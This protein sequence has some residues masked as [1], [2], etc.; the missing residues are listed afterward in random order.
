MCGRYNLITDAQALVDFFELRNSLLI[1]PRY[2]IAPSQSIP[3]VRADGQGRELVFQR[4]GLVPHWAKES[5]IGYSMINARAETVAE[6]PSFRDA[7]RYRRCL[8]PA[9]GF[10]EWKP[11]NAGKQPYNIRIG[12]GLLFAFAGLWESWKGEDNKLLETCTIIVT[13]ANDAISPI[14]DRMPVVL[15]P[16]EYSTWLAPT[17]TDPDR[18]TPLLRPCPADWVNSYPVSR[19]V[20]SPKNDSPECILPVGL[21]E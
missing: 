19:L 8:I 10:Y 2:N 12:D 15:S 18:L 16:S 1:E 9:T 13:K 17:I 6:K 3:V 4:W 21:T 14:H 20:G 5:K 7:F 11:I